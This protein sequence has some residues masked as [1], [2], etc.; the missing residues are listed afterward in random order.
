MA[1]HV[2]E[3]GHEFDLGVRGL[4]ARDDE[5]LLSAVAEG[6]VVAAERRAEGVEL[7]AKVLG[8]DGDDVFRDARGRDLDTSMYRP[9]LLW[10][11]PY[12]HRTFAKGEALKRRSASSSEALG[13]DTRAS[14]ARA[15]A[16]CASEAAALA[17]SNAAARDASS[18]SSV[19]TGGP[20][21]SRDARARTTRTGRAA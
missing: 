2:A 4:A 8:G 18:A 14:T 9:A 11:Y 7:A 10:M 21:T 6:G 15:Y 20:R 13:G 5:D 19:P 3:F 1:E 17:A 12:S 16:A